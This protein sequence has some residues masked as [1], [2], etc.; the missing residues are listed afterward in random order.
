MVRTIF[1]MRQTVCWRVR[2]LSHVS[3]E[4][5][6]KTWKLNIE[7]FLPRILQ[8]STKNK[9]HLNTLNVVSGYQNNIQ[10]QS[11]ALKLQTSRHLPAQG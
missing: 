1:Y 10:A 3:N 7:R 8:R 5:K 9:F 11:V 6:L 4:K 2:V